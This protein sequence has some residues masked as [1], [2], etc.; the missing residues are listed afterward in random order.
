MSEIS[1][2][3]DRMYVNQ[4][5]KRMNRGREMGGGKETARQVD[6]IQENPV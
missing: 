6:K 2:A 1:S 3:N 4:N 5:M